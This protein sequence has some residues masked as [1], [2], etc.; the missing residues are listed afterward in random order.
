[1][2]T[3]LEQLQVTLSAKVDQFKQEMQSAVREFDRDANQIEQRNL[4]LGQSMNTSMK[5]AAESTR[6]LSGA[7]KSLLS[8]Y[9]FHE[10]IDGAIKANEQIAQMAR[11]ADLAR[12]SVERFQQIQFAA[13]TLGGADPADVQKAAHDLALT[14]NKEV[15]EGEGELTNILKANNM[16]LTDRNGKAKD[17]NQ[18][19]EMAAT[20]LQRAKT[21]A[22]AID[23]GRLF[24]LSEEMVRALE[25]GPE[26]FKRAQE[27]AK[28]A[29]AVLDEG[30]V[31]K[32]KEFDKAWNETW[33]KFPIYAKAAA[34]EAIAALTPFGTWLERLFARIPG[35]AKAA[36]QAGGTEL[37]SAEGAQD[38]LDRTLKF[39]PDD[40]NAIRVA[41]ERLAA[42]QERDAEKNARARLAA[43]LTQQEDERLKNRGVA[44][45]QQFGPNLPDIN[46]PKRGKD[47]AEKDDELD[48]EE[49]R[50]QKQINALNGQAA[51]VGKVGEAAAKAEAEMRLW[52]AAQAAG[53][54]DTPALRLQIEKLADAYAKVKV[55]L[56]AGK[57]E[58][59]LFFE[60]SQ[61]GRTPDEQA[62][63]SRIR[64]A[65]LDP[66]SKDAQDLADKMR[67]IQNLTEG[68]EMAG[69]FVK[70]LISDLENGVKAGRALEN[71]LKRIADKLADKAID[72]LIS[73]L[74]GGLSK[75][76]FSGGIGVPAQAGGGWAGQGPLVNVPASAF[77]GARH[78]AA[79]GGIPAILHAGEI[80]LNQAQ[81]KNVA[82]GLGPSKAVTITH[83]PT[84]NGTGLSAEQVF[85]VVQRSQ[86]EFARQIGPIF[87]DWQMRHG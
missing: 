26:A 83:A 2:A 87:N 86:K 29:G 3:D 8:A 34:I 11:R 85:S 75:G 76:L 6:F 72:S 27:A 43:T 51:A 62:I 60:R 18:L 25:K 39:N 41:R 33:S 73:G 50:I 45:T 36:V 53:R 13:K 12:V 56:A 74:F 81:Q 71:Q 49:K 48:R 65:G 46:D 10:L 55:E 69:S 63:A 66:A 82:Q 1:M 42:A 35:M 28:S 24:N 4:Q 47:K 16:S 58:Q 59:D 79:G 54:T 23:I 77:I 68:K 21:E 57:L 40:Q 22:Q 17:F 67:T 80:V 31:Q 61:I 30:L 9:T 20:L 14:A 84:I 37:Q 64:G 5:S 78:F 52:E 32:A 38:I 70:G 15:R 44:G 19:L 7:L